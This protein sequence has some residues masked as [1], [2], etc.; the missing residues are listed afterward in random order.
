MR[1]LLV[2]AAVAANVTGVGVAF[3]PQAAGALALA[4]LVLFAFV[5]VVLPRAAHGA[6]VAGEHAAAARRYRLLARVSLAPARRAAA[7]VSV[8]G[9]HL[10]AGNFQHGAEILDAIDADLLDGPSQAAWLNNRAYAVLRGGLG[11][12][13]EALTW[14]E[15]AIAARPDV[16]GLVH[17][18]G[19]ALLAVGRLDDAIRAFDSMWSSGDLQP[20]L[21]AERCLDLA[22]AWEQKGHPDYAAD[23]RARAARSQGGAAATR[24][25]LGFDDEG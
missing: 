10:T 11:D 21:E 16:P 20:R 7:W 24:A 14:A 19:V 8:A 2:L 22:R 25:V 17:T 5:I 18:H 23:Y 9:C 4:W 15:R 3:G 12:P 6:F 1:R 13:R